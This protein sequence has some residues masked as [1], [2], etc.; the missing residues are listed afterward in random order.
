MRLGPTAAALLLGSATAHAFVAPRAPLRLQQPLKHVITRAQFGGPG[1]GNVFAIA[2]RGNDCTSR[3]V[4]VSQTRQRTRRPGGA[5]MTPSMMYRG[6][7]GLGGGGDRQGGFN[8]DLGTAVT[9][10]FAFLL[11]FAPG[12]I[13]GVFTTFLLVSVLRGSSWSIRV[14]RV[15]VLFKI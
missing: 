6:G 8:F 13:S 15:L 12:V 10:G 7:G 5:V 9:L 3:S 1:G 11:F 2:D 4:T 14:C